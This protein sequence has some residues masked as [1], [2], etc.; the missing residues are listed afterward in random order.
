MN[1]ESGQWIVCEATQ[2]KGQ[3]KYYNHKTVCVSLG[4]GITLYITPGAL[5]DLG[6]KPIC[7]NH[8]SE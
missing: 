3:V 8:K 1:W 4:E 5:K 7:L 2:V 6:W